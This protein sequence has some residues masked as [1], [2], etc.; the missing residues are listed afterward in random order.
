MSPSPSP[1]ALLVEMVGGSSAPWWGVPVI[2]GGFLI[3]GAALGFLF[4]WLIENRKAKA[5]LR[6]RFVDQTL[7]FSSKVLS[8]A[9][10]LRR[11]SLYLG[12]S[13]GAE[14]HVKNRASEQAQR[15]A[16][17]EE[18]VRR[19]DLIIAGLSSLTL[20]TPKAIRD[21]GDKFGEAAMELGWMN[22]ATSTDVTAAL[23][24]FEDTKNTFEEAVRR[25]FGVAA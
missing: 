17:E 2:A 25:L 18:M 4:N 23:K 5:A 16:Y 3:L 15:L 21:A 7:G 20:I 13:L 9:S 24:Q 11:H 14:E 6:T 8:D 19:T 12:A 22:K 10:E 1:S